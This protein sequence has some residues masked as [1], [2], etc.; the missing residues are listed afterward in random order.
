MSTNIYRYVNPPSCREN[1]ANTNVF[2]RQYVS[3]KSVCAIACT[4]NT[5]R[6]VGFNYIKADSGEDLCEY[7]GA[8]S[9]ENSTNL[10]HRD[11]YKYFEQR[12]VFGWEQTTSQKMATGGGTLQMEI[13]WNIQ[14]GIQ[15]SRMAEVEKTLEMSEQQVTCSQS[16]PYPA[17]TYVP[18]TGSIWLGADDIVQDGDWRWNAANG[19]PVDYSEWR[20]NEPNG[21]SGE[22]CM[23]L[24]SDGA[25]NDESCSSARAFLCEG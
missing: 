10:V 16:R 23:E 24:F 11:G 21:G 13:R 8:K 6:C 2:G 18:I 25:W 14:H 19:E 5:P 17:Y 3:T 9:D 15:L 1:V 7:A 12:A 20:P 22:N 4:A